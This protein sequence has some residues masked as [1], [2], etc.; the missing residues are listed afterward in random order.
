MVNTPVRRERDERGAARRRRTDPGVEAQGRPRRHG[1][2]RGAV[3]PF[4]QPSPPDRTGQT[5]PWRA[6][7]RCPRDVSS[8]KG[9]GKPGT[10]GKK[11]RKRKKGHNDVGFV[12]ALDRDSLVS[13]QFTQ[14]A[15][16][17]TTR[18]CR[19]ECRTPSSWRPPPAIQ[20]SACSSSGREGELGR[21]VRFSTGLVVNQPIGELG[22]GFSRAGWDAG[23]TLGDELC[24]VSQT[25]AGDRRGEAIVCGI[26]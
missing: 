7:A 25:G 6:A 18:R 17:G 22:V 8:F 14:G 19:T 11:K 13:S 10:R 21:G 26:R 15:W 1:V 12:G 23:G 4:R 24:T 16:V 5:H 3:K 9:Y 20:T 2:A